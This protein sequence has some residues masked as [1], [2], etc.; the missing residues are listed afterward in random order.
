MPMSV[1]IEMASGPSKKYLKVPL[2]E[3]GEVR[4]GVPAVYLGYRQ[5][6]AHTS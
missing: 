3:V 4:A 6:R 1:G 2:L 5:S